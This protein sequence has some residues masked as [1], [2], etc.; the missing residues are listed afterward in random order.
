MY[1][2]KW[3]DI[4]EKNQIAFN[5][6]HNKIVFRIKARD[7]TSQVCKDYWMTNSANKDMNQINKI[8]KVLL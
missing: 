3:G 1:K 2:N 8:R 5:I 7:R 6:L 4:K